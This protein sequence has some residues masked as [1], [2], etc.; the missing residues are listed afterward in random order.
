MAK[1]VHHVV[2]C[3]IYS[4]T[5]FSANTNVPPSTT[6]FLMTLS[7]TEYISIGGNRNT[8]A[9]DWDQQ[10]GLLAFGADQNVALWRPQNKSQRGVSN[11]LRG[12][13][14]KVTAVKFGGPSE[15]LDQTLITGSADGEL[16]RWHSKCNSEA[17]HCSTIVRAHEGSINAIS[18][19]S[20]STL[21]ATAGA[22]ATV[23]VWTLASDGASL[24]H[25]IPLKPRYIPLTVV[26]GSFSDDTAAKFMAVGGTRD[27][28]QLYILTANDVK[29]QHQLQATLSGH[30][31]WIRSLALRFP[32]GGIEKDIILA[33]VSQD[34]YVRLW[35]FHLGDAVFAKD[36]GRQDEIAAVEQGLTSKVQTIDSA[37][38]KYSITFEALLVGHEDW[39]Y[40]ARW[41]PSAN[42]LQLL[43]ASA[44]NSLTIW[45]P[46]PTS[47]IWVSTARL[48]EISGQKGATT[49]TGSAGGFWIGLWSPNGQAVTCLGRTGSWRLW[50]NDSTLQY[51]VQ[52]SGISGHVGSL[53]GLSWDG[54]G[55][56]LL[57]T[58]ADQTTRM[59]AEWRRDSTSTWHEFARPQI[60]GY[61]LNC[62]TSSG[63]NQFISGAEEKLLRVFNKTKAVANMM[64]RLCTIST[65]DS[66]SMAEAANM[67][68]LG[69]SNKAVDNSAAEDVEPDQKNGETPI[70][71]HVDVL[72]ITSPPHEDILA[73]HT[74]WPEHEKLYGHGYEIS[75]VVTNSDVSIVATA[76]KA[77]SIDHAV[78]RLYDTKDWH[79]IKP[80]LTAHSLTV[81]RLQF[82]HPPYKYLLSVGRD[83]QWAV[84]QQEG[85]QS[86]KWTLVAK[87]EKAHSRMIL[88]AAWLPSEEHCVFAT[89]GRDKAVKTWQ[90]QQ[91]E[92]GQE[93][94]CK[95]TISRQ[96]P[97]T[98]IVFSALS[99]DQKLAC[100]AVGE[101][102]GQIS[103]HVVDVG[104]LGV[105]KAWD[106]EEVMCPSKAVTRLAW[107][108]RK[109]EKGGL[110]SLQGNGD[111][112]KAAQ[113]AVGSADAS[114]RIMRIE[115]ERE[116]R[117]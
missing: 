62:I 114:L 88:D 13:N 20:H 110:A 37:G 24:I 39:I 89:A 65:P 92:G 49:A 68:V 93:F 7:T 117:G 17:W 31:G 64:A 8:S 2:I 75:E 111:E 28:I 85:S 76:C 96:S 41:N 10:S 86:E 84:F 46:D 101:E 98:A 61:N 23:K 77:S 26:L 97:I 27:S 74:L 60:H 81:T 33:S 99:Q 115:W 109:E 71:K 73:R 22:D 9:A 103:I 32:S 12:H 34:K 104:S 113:L 52:K 47:G 29:L 4:G 94:V 48:G 108:P 87:N 90:R 51:W 19:L 36:R 66:S 16:R 106:L 50:E 67:P 11:L 44:D 63:P 14:G 6:Y 79:E 116:C 72:D 42:S 35:R 69:L 55:D 21:F 91:Q 95:S 40:T 58:G 38:V 30:E 54:Y 57:S 78:I 102:T 53:N 3:V 5:N 100:L 25:S 112:Y 83:R 59:H 70:P 15:S 82:S 80:P 107:R 56:Y 43:T 105:V 45:E 18:T 1:I